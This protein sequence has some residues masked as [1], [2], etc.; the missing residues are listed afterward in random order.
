MFI[1]IFLSSAPGI[2]LDGGD[3]STFRVLSW[4]G[5]PQENSRWKQF[6]KQN[7]LEDKRLSSKYRGR[8]GE[9]DMAVEAVPWFQLSNDV[10]IKQFKFIVE[11]G[12]SFLDSIRIT[13]RYAKSRGTFYVQLEDDVLTKKGFI[14]IMK[15]FALEK[16]ADKQSWS[17]DTF[18]RIQNLF[19]KDLH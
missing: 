3:F 19:S 14:S 4:P 13:A 6:S 5:R 12:F 17:D 1:Y 7:V 11:I 8:Y 9:G 15:H 2:R 10:S 18:A 16:I